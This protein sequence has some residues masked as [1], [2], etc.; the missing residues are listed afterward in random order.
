MSKVIAIA[1]QKGGVGKTTTTI[2]LG[3]AF[4]RAG[5][6]VLL[7]DVDSSG[8]MTSGLG[9]AKKFRTSIKDLMEEE[10]MAEDYGDYDV[11][12]A[13]LHHRT[14]TEQLDL[15][16]SNKLLTG[17]E[18][19]L[20]KLT[21]NKELVLKGVLEH[22]REEYD[23]ILIDTA[24]VLNM[25]TIN[26][27]GAADSVLIPVQPAKYAI[28]GLGELVKLIL[29][30]QKSYNPSLQF[31]GMVYTID[32]PTFNETKEN[33]SRVDSGYGDKVRIFNTT[34]PRLTELSEA[35][36]YGISIFDHAPS[37]NGAWAYTKL[38]REV[39]KNE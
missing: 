11:H 23:Y 28:D 34:I 10:I 19:Y 6:K 29:G 8:N 27:L 37:G 12:E 38:A 17:V 26:A 18:S 35:P 7:V 21:M 24:P 32:T 5:K 15:L 36:S 22:I 2:N 4:A 16:P 1:N 3:A 31:E 9:F 39:M 20:S 33:K 25:M 30:A 14:E 13:I